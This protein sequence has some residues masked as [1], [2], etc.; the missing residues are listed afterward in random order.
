M[1]LRLFMIFLVAAAPCIVLAEDMELSP[2]DAAGAGATGLSPLGRGLMHEATALIESG[3]Y[4]D[5]EKPLRRVLAL[6]P[7][8]REAKSLLLI[9]LMQSPRYAEAAGL[10]AAMYPDARDD[11]RFLNNYAWFL[12]TTSDPAFRDPKRALALAQEAVLIAP[13]V[14]NVWSTLAEARYINGDFP[15]AERAMRHA[16]ELAKQQS[17]PEATVNGYLGELQK[18]AEANAVMS[19]VE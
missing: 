4:L 7:D 6:A 18:M 1:R 13:A 8:Y 2:V 16:V 15:R 19:L 9:V 14:Y 5:A 10:F 3:Y 12:A 11:Y 17:A